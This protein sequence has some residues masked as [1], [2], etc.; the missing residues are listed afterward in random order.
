MTR[1]APR[2]LI[3]DDEPYVP[4]VLELKLQ[5]AGYRTFIARN[6]N[7]GLDLIVRTRPDVV[8]TD[9]S[10]P[11]MSGFQLCQEAQSL[12]ET[13]PFLLIVVTSRTERD[14]RAWVKGIP[15]VHF[16]EKPISPRVILRTIEAN[17]KPG[18]TVAREQETPGDAV[19]GT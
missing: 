15:D 8:I 14:L 17:L 16:I 4:R 7:E 11:G 2:V 13:D 9:I 10:M 19:V 18:A 3:V 12:R 6:G 5:R 1:E